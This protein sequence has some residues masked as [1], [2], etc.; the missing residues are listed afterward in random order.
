MSGIVWTDVLQ[1]T[2]MTVSS[3][4]IAVIAWKA[5]GSNQLNVP[6]GWMNPF[7]DWK[8][9]MD[10]TGIIDEVNAKIKSDGY[11]IIGIYVYIP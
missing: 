8:L 10:W 3:I 2:V 11:L 1:Y 5:M 6:N 9:N 4:A 7:F